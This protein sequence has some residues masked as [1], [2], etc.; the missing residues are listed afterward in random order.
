MRQV[1]FLRAVNVGG[2]S[3]VRMADVQTAFTAAGCANVTTF[4][5]SGNVMFDAPAGGPAAAIDRRI[6][7][8]LARLLGAEL[9]IV[10]RSID[11]LRKLVAGAPFGALPDD[12]ALKL[13]VMFVVQKTKQR[14]R[15]PLHLPKEGLEAIGM[16]GG[17]VLIVS[18]R[19][20][21]GWYGFPTT[22]IEKELGI[23]TTARS[24]S[25]VKKIVELGAMGAKS[26]KGAKGA[27]VRTV[28]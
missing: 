14:P 20:P 22:W 1:A 25:T 17:D 3:I 6:R 12:R 5:A 26:A 15:F 27:I 4:I 16:I 28:R 11:G 2:T 8:N 18:R 23:V 19:K 13:Y 7:T 21:N 10:Y 9:V 24:W